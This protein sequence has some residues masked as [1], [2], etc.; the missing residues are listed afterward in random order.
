MLI[1]KHDTLIYKEKKR[2]DNYKFISFS[3]SGGTSASDL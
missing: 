3:V 1:S 2:L